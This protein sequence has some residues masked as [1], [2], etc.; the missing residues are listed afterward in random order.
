[1]ALVRLH[2]N[3]TKRRLRV[4]CKRGQF[5]GCKTE[6]AHEQSHSR[7]PWSRVGLCYSADSGGALDAR[8]ETAR[9]R[10]TNRSGAGPIKENG[11]HV[12]NVSADSLVGLIT[13]TSFGGP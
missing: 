13:P 1:M 2:V 10:T 4:L 8:G 11:K 5:C 6:I 12:I 9:A 7:T 3:L